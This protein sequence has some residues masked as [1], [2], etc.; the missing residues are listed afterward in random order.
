MNQISMSDLLE[1]G[2]ASL[3][4]S[5]TA[6]GPRP[7]EIFGAMAQQ[8]LA[9]LAISTSVPQSALV[10]PTPAPEPT[11]AAIAE[12]TQGDDDHDEP[13][14]QSVTEPESNEVDDYSFGMD[15]ESYGRLVT[16]RKEPL[17]HRAGLL[18]LVL[19]IAYAN[20]DLDLIA[21]RSNVREKSI[22]KII[23]FAIANDMIRRSSTKSG[24]YGLTQAGY[25][26]WYRHL[27]YRHTKM[28]PNELFSLMKT[29]QKYRFGELLMLTGAN[30]SANE[31]SRA[32][33]TE[34]IH[35]M[36]KMFTASGMIQVIDD[37][38]T[39]LYVVPRSTKRFPP[40]PS[41]K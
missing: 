7:A 11:D 8:L 19:T 28:Q 39:P 32:S 15:L 21:S 40:Q 36:L 26:Q 23:K 29:G 12:L 22:Q 16:G 33:E 1:A 3:T 4:I 25:E 38:D 41:L 2:P 13:T 37:A 6:T 24:V 18:Q 30:T 34:V 35:T 31:N 10:S 14:N 9:N 27:N 20:L 17:A 5:I